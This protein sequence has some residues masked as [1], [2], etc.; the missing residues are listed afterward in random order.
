MLN[1]NGATYNEKYNNGFHIDSVLL[2]NTSQVKPDVSLQN[3]WLII[4]EH[5]KEKL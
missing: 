3:T 5:Q 2:R 4:M 1:V